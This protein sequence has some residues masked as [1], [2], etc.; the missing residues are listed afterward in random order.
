MSEQNFINKP[1]ST[2]INELSDLKNYI[3]KEVGLSEWTIITQDQIDAFAKITD[4]NQWIHIN[5]ELCKKHSPYKKPVAHGFLV[6]S[7]APKFC[8]ETLKFNNVSMG[9]NYGCDKVRF[10]NA[11]RVNSSIRARIFLISCEQIEGGSRYKLKIIYE[12]KDQEKPACV[13]EFIAIA[14]R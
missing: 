1:Y 4:D 3:G 10:M 8:Y 7:L 14:Y 12:L 5:P 2:E 11:T 13:A 9:V 6:L